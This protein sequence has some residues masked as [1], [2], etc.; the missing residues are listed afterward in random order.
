MN[1]DLSRNRSV[2]IKSDPYF[3]EYSMMDSSDMVY[4]ISSVITK[5]G[6]LKRLWVVSYR[7]RLANSIHN[8]GFVFDTKEEAMDYINQNIASFYC[9]FDQ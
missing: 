3:E 9:W 1:I 5:T 2:W 6:I 8:I 4:C 7:S